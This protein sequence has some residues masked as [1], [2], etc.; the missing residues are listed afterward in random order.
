[1]RFTERGVDF[2]FGGGPP[3]FQHSNAFHANIRRTKRGVTLILLNNGNEIT[4]LL[5]RWGISRQTPLFAEIVPPE[6]WNN[7]NHLMNF[8]VRNADF[9]FGGGP[10]LFQHSNDFRAN[11]SR[12]KRGGTL[13]LIHNRHAITPLLT[14]GEFRGK[15]PFSQRYY[16]L[17][18]ETTEIA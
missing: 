16:L 5:T 17:N 3:L 2:G 10:L 15:S 13:I 6:N 12:T 14:H 18:I 9:I 7:R 11:I 1:M 8:T 4:L